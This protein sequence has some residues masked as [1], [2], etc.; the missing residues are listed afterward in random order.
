MTKTINS[1]PWGR[2]F[3]SSSSGPSSSATHG[4]RVSIS[5]HSFLYFQLGAF[6]FVFLLKND[7]VNGIVVVK[8]KDANNQKSIMDI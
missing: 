3:T 7:L 8:L 5:R 1:G 2:L 4:T 6:Y